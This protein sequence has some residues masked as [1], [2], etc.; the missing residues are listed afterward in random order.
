[1]GIVAL[2]WIEEVRIGRVH[3]PRISAVVVELLQVLPIDVACHWA[4]SI[5]NLY[6]RRIVHT[7]R[8]DMRKSALWPGLNGQQ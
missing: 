8:P 3:P 1:M 2:A 5:V 4:E 7:W 6:A